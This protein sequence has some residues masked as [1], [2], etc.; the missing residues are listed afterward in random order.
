[1]KKKRQFSLPNRIF[2]TR[3]DVSSK[4]QRRQL[5]SLEADTELGRLPKQS[6][7]EEVSS[8]SKLSS[9]VDHRQGDICGCVATTH[10]MIALLWLEEGWQ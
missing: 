1:M 9:R 3:N 4:Q 8:V 7:N 6:Q 10:V 2:P 5:P